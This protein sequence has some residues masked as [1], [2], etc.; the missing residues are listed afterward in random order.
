MDPK[1]AIPVSSF[2]I[3]L[4]LFFIYISCRLPP[5]YLSLI[6]SLCICNTNNRNWL[7]SSRSLNT[8]CI[9]SSWLLTHSSLLFIFSWFHYFLYKFLRT[10]NRINTKWYFYNYLW[11]QKIKTKNKGNRCL[12][13]VF[14]NFLKLKLKF[15]MTIP[16]NCNI[17]SWYHLQATELV[18]TSSNRTQALNEESTM[19]YR[20][21]TKAVWYM[22]DKYF[23]YT[24]T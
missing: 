10:V 3:N 5:Q 8:I 12:I 21:A 19:P 18:P 15:H 23:I 22:F 9:H 13:F 20:C 4:N 11:K 2:M 7:H 16:C 14:E 6:F 1:L 17:T 24:Y